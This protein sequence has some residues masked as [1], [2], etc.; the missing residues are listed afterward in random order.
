MRKRLDI[1][2]IDR[3]L[4]ACNYLDV[5]SLFYPQMLCVAGVPGAGKTEFIK[6]CFFS[7]FVKVDPDAF[8]KF[9]PGYFELEHKDVVN[10]TKEVSDYISAYVIEE[11]IKRKYSIVITSTFTDL[12][13]WDTKFDELYSMLM[14]NMYTCKLIIL[15]QPFSQCMKGFQLRS[16]MSS[17]DEP[18]SRAFDRKFFNEKCKLFD[19]SMAKHANS[20]FF[21]EVIVLWRNRLEDDYRRVDNCYSSLDKI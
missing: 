3:I 6:N 16:R 7:N 15:K 17:L 11:S 14:N 19:K 5:E 2:Q 21:D 8:R 20:S 9:S 12:N 13:F 4:K 18:N 1:S 10:G